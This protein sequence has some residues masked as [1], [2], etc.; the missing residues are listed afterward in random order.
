M[1][2]I[3]AVAAIPAWCCCLHPPCHELSSH[4]QGCLRF[5]SI[6]SPLSLHAMAIAT[7]DQCDSILETFLTNHRSSEASQSS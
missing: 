2:A 5:G 7:N 3:A 1:Q 4:R 6:G